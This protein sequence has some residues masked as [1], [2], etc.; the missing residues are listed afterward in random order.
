MSHVHH[1]YV[2]HAITYSLTNS[3]SHSLKAAKDADA[4]AARKEYLAYSEILQ[5]L[6]EQGKL[7]AAQVQ[8]ALESNPTLDAT[9]PRPLSCPNLTPTFILP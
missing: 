9:L 3:L 5:Q 2:H 6:V 8:Q 4:A 1:A 7:T